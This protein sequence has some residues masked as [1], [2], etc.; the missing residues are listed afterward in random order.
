MSVGRSL[1]ASGPTQALREGLRGAPSLEIEV[2]VARELAPTWRRWAYT[3]RADLARVGEE[4]VKIPVAQTLG[5]VRFVGV[6]GSNR[7]LNTMVLVP[8]VPGL[9]AAGE[10]VLAESGHVMLGAAPSAARHVPSAFVVTASR[11]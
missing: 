7:A 2:E 4:E 9:A 1:A 3:T 10:P 5:R 8:T 6:S 11:A